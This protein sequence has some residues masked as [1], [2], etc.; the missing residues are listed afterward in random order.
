MRAIS[1]IDEGGNIE[2]AAAWRSARAGLASQAA[3]APAPISAARRE[4]ARVQHHL[5]LH[6]SARTERQPSRRCA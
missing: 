5:P 6:S 1:V 4:I 2:L 3:T